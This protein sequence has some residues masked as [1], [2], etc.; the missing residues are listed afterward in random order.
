MRSPSS[1][2]EA[3]VLVLGA[4]YLPSAVVKWEKAMTLLVKGAATLLS[5]YPGLFVRS[6]SVEYPAP[7]VIVSRGRLRRKKQ[8]ARFSR[9]GVYRRDEYRCQYCGEPFEADE[10]TL[11]HVNPKCNG[12]KLTWDNSVAACKPCNQRKGGRTPKEAGMSVL[13]M[14]AVPGF[15]SFADL[16]DPDTFPALWD[17]FLKVN[18]T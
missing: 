12:G 9:V 14:P 15:L 18:K 10:L 13:N 16:H 1:L 7:A 8:T 6:V 2:R 3:R 11:D 5:S 17:P 4:D